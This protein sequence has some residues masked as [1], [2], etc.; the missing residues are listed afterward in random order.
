M[1]AAVEN[2]TDHCEEENTIDGEI[3]IQDGDVEREVCEEEVE[4]KRE[5]ITELEDTEVAETIQNGL[6]EYYENMKNQELNNRQ[7][8][9]DVG[10]LYE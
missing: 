2:G 1:D 8:E 5:E 4:G 6:D 10:Y 9:D 7:R 3:P